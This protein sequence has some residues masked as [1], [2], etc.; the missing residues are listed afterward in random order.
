MN[1]IWSALAVEDLNGIEE[2]IARDNPARAVSFINELI[3]LGDSLSIE[4]EAWKGTPA[5]WIHDD[6]VRELYYKNYTIVYQ[7]HGTD[8]IIHEVHNSAK[9]SRKMRG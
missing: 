7:I 2:F 3:D 9:L 8:I 1:I 4:G 5:K 6:H